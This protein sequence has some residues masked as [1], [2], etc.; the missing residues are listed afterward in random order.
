MENIGRITSAG[1]LAPRKGLLSS[2]P[3]IQIVPYFSGGF[4]IV[5]RRLL[6]VCPGFIQRK[7]Q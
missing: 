3:R 5:S 6:V 4:I 2:Q 7:L 1:K